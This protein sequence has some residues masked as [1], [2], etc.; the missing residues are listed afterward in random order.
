MVLAGF[1]DCTLQT[2][3]Y[4]CKAEIVCSRHRKGVVFSAGGVV[5]EAVEASCRCSGNRCCT[6]S[7]GD[8]CRGSPG[9]VGWLCCRR[10]LPSVIVT[11]GL[12]PQ[13]TSRVLTGWGRR[14]GPAP[15]CWV[16]LGLDIRLSQIGHRPSL[17]GVVSYSRACAVTKPGLFA[18][19][20]PSCVETCQ[21]F[22]W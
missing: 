11:G 17:E 19:Q 6:G 8:R 12:E 16:A 1:R 15:R 20:Q 14:I 13:T 18:T 3:V 10:R 2:Y 9:R 21:R 4:G 7:A 22:F 5:R